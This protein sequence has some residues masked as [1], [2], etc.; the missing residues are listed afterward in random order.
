MILVVPIYERV[1][2]LDSYSYETDRTSDTNADN[3]LSEIQGLVCPA[4]ELRKDP[5][6]RGEIQASDLYE[7]RRHS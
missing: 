3:Q 2:L 4:N 1:T 5:N 6:G 7:S